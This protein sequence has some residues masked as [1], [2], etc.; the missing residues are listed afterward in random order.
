MGFLSIWPYAAVWAARAFFVF[1]FFVFL[2]CFYLALRF[3]FTGNP[4]RARLYSVHWTGRHCLS[5]LLMHAGNSDEG[6][7]E[8]LRFPGI[9][10]F[11]NLHIEHILDI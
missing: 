11:L 1:C 9:S 2:V 8:R 10:L 7:I 5:I 6:V 3:Y 4:A